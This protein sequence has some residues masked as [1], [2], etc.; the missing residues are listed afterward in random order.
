MENS[1]LIGKVPD[2]KGI[3]VHPI[4]SN[5][6]PGEEWQRVDALCQ[7]RRKKFQDQES[8]YAEKLRYG[9]LE[10][11]ERERVYQEE[12][13]RSGGMVNDGMERRRYGLDPPL[14]PFEGNWD[15]AECTPKERLYNERLY[16]GQMKP[17][18]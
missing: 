13:K 18:E 12:K 16:I 1:E 15:Q 11:R 4:C 7:E 2:E 14:G 3:L 8:R 6:S 17:A 10:E 9:T 5:P